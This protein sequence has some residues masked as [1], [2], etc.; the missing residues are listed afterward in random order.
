M[1]DVEPAANAVRPW[2]RE[3]WPWLL[4]AGPAAVVAAGAVTIWL[5]VS[6]PDPVIAKHGAPAA[7]RR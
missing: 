1:N 6:H 7:A 4:A 3:P 5:A 2:Y